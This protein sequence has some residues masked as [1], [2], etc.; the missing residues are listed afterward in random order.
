MSPTSI[1]NSRDALPTLLEQAGWTNWADNRIPGFG[2]YIN[3]S[4][5]KVLDGREII[6][7]REYDLAQNYESPAHAVKECAEKLGDHPL[8]VLDESLDRLKENPDI[9]LGG[10]LFV[11]EAALEFHEPVLEWHK[12]LGERIQALDQPTTVTEDNVEQS[13][14]DTDELT[15][16]SKHVET[17]VGPEATT[18]AYLEVAGRM[19]SD[20]PVD[21]LR[22]DAFGFRDYAE[23]L[24]GLINDPATT[25]P[26][27]LAINAPWGAG[28][29]S[30][31]MM[32]KNLLDTR[33]SASGS[34]P[35][36]T[37]WFNAWMHDGAEALDAALCAEVGRVADQRCRWW[38]RHFWQSS[39][40]W[41]TGLV[42]TLLGAAAFF[43]ASEGLPVEVLAGKNN[44]S[45]AAIL[46]ILAPSL[47]GLGGV[48][49]FAALAGRLYLT[50]GSQLIRFIHRPHEAP[51]SGNMRQVRSQLGK[52]IHRAT[53]RGSRFVIFIDDIERCH[54]PK[55]VD[56]L[57]AVNQLLGH[58]NVVIVL[59]GDMPAVA[60]NVELKYQDDHDI[61][62]AQ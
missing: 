5:P 42:L 46:N 26:L 24:H 44:E 2:Y 32:V 47:G 16:R 27:V 52:I 12:S 29:S 31:G 21:D 20:E 28:K 15:L 18:A 57:E 51:S 55:A 40:A 41:T 54:P 1:M 23:A 45:L 37:M 4:H 53:P 49:A 58:E 13:D 25:T 11:R 8:L 33:P 39:R 61:L 3:I 14:T 50:L 36:L 59:M 35:H 30:L 22:Q 60:A 34:K 56:L 19:L 38:R 7:T 9:P 6:V 43:V 62:V 10:G 48:A 17:E